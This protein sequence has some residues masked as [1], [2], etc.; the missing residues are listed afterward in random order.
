MTINTQRIPTYTSFDPLKLK[1]YEHT[2]ED[3]ME[4]IDNTLLINKLQEV[5]ADMIT[6]PNEL[7]KVRLG[8]I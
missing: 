3:V 1:Y 2:L 8:I 4:L 6:T 5:E 7:N